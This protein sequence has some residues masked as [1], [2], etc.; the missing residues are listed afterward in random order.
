MLRG[1]DGSDVLPMLI[2]Q[3]PTTRLAN[4][5]P[6]PS[7]CVWQFLRI[8]NPTLPFV[9]LTLSVEKGQVG[10]RWFAVRQ[11][12]AEGSRGVTASDHR[13]WNFDACVKLAVTVAAALPVF[14][15]RYAA[16]ELKTLDDIR[17]IVEETKVDWSVRRKLTDD[18]LIKVAEVARLN[19]R[20]PTA[21]VAETLKTSHRNASR[22]M[23]A[24][25]ER[26]FT[27]KENS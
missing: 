20:R 14:N 7:V 13:W 1:V 9:D 17:Q 18:L 19:P 4:G 8:S 6:F 10:V 15:E 27:M 11:S 22:W 16:G 26:G 2:S 5:S 3:G 25:R 12:V 24:A 23:A 21:A